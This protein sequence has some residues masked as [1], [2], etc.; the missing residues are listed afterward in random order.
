VPEL[1]LMF[2]RTEK[3]I[4]SAGIRTPDCPAR[5]LFSIPTMLSELSMYSANPRPASSVSHSKVFSALNFS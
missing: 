2:W 1:V 5:S 4:A 3:S